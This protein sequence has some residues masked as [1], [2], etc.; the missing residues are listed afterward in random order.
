MCWKPAAALPKSW[1]IA[2]LSRSKEI[3][4]HMSR[5]S[6]I[7][8]STSS[9]WSRKPHGGLLLASNTAEIPQKEWFTCFDDFCQ[10]RTLASIPNWL[11]NSCICLRRKFHWPPVTFKIERSWIQGSE[12][13]KKGEALML[14]VGFLNP[15]PR[16]IF[17]YV[18]FCHKILGPAQAKRISRTAKPFRINSSNG[19]KSETRKC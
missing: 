16:N 17:R 14:D 3:C 18:F 2:A 8:A 11:L 1:K 12:T 6:R 7:A 5:S 19:K 9:V 10:I 13:D 15:S 4:G